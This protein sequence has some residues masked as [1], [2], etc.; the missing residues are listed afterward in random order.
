MQVSPGNLT[1]FQNMALQG[2]ILT[3]VDVTPGTPIFTWPA[4]PYMFRLCKSYEQQQQSTVSDTCEVLSIG[5]AQTDAGLS[6]GLLI[7]LGQRGMSCEHFNKANF[8]IKYCRLI[9]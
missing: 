8:G 7:Q 6:G 2:F 3:H 5:E 9:T 1:L 4:K